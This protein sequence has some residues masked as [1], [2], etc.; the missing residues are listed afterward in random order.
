[1]ADTVVK[2]LWPPVSV[3]FSFTREMRIRE[4]ETHPQTSLIISI[5]LGCTH[6][7]PHPPQ[8]HASGLRF[9]LKARVMSKPT[10]VLVHKFQNRKDHRTPLQVTLQGTPTPPWQVACLT[11]SYYKQWTGNRKWLRTPFFLT[12]R[13]N[14]WYRWIMM[15]HCSREV[16]WIQVSPPRSFRPDTTEW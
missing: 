2:L 3:L 15:L 4:A 8:T 5:F 7:I 9:K 16:N 10:H 6:D 1:M 12:L 13:F 14:D 11:L